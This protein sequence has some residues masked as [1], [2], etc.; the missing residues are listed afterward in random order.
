[1]RSC[2]FASDNSSGVH[3][4]IMHAL[5]E[6]NH[7]STEGYGNDPWTDKAVTGLQ[8]MFG[9]DVDVWLVPHGTGA[10]VLSL[11]AMARPWQT[12][13]LADAAHPVTAESSAVEAVAGCR[14]AL[15]PSAHGK[16]RPESIAP[17]MHVHA[18]HETAPGVL[19]L[20]QCTEYGTVYSAKEL[21]ELC[22]EAKRNGLPVFMDGARFAN[23]VAATGEDPR[24]L[25]KDAGVD[26]M[27]F[28]GTKNGLMYGEAILI[29]NPAF[30][31]EFG[32]QRK[33]ALQLLSKQRFLGAQ[34][35]ACLEKDLW[36]SMATHANA[37]A[38][39]L[40]DGLRGMSHMTLAHPVETNA[41]FVNM[42]PDHI[43]TLQKDFVFYEV[44]AS[45]HTARFMCAFNTDPAE[46]DKLLTTM[47]NLV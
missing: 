9:K 38:A 32:T 42:Q 15:L 21:R 23:A 28:G 40:A 13:L 18:P 31:R 5:M 26:M 19:A 36:L 6:A 30:A 1:M 41:V 29:F 35:A 8:A 12:V 45:A 37:M 17:A 33:Q 11:R 4:H 7:G 44:D 24:E 39:R 20:T 27:T 14:L 47:A 34:F 10:N 25:T 22:A 16:I 46:V 43:A 2:T 3:P